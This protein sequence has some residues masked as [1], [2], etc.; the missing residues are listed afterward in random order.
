M[1][2]SAEIDIRVSPKSSRSS[3]VIDE[4]HQIKVYL[5]SPPVDGKANAEC[6]E[7][8]SKK[9]KIAKSAIIIKKG[10]KG[11]NKKLVITGF[12]FDEV[13]DILRGEGK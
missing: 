4:E 9:L 10:D 13:I 5:H 12:T 11:K 8:F 3:I 6:L 1:P 7:L 2:K